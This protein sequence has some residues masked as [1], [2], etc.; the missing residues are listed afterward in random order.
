[1]RTWQ[2]GDMEMKSMNAPNQSNVV[3]VSCR[4]PFAFLVCSLAALDVAEYVLALPPSIGA[5]AKRRM[6]KRLHVSRILRHTYEGDTAFV[7]PDRMQGSLLDITSGSY[8]ARKL[9]VRRIGNLDDEAR[10]VGTAL[11]LHMGR[12][13]LVTTPLGH[14]YGGGIAR[15]T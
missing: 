9:V 13:V 14:S 12:K 10:S 4:D 1:M 11:N 5:Q 2:V 8:G 7:R 6:I 15:A 3:M